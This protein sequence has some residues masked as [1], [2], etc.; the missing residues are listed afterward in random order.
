MG[1]RGGS[2]VIPSFIQ[3]ICSIHLACLDEVTLPLGGGILTPIPKSVPNC[4][5]AF[6]DE[7]FYAICLKCRCP[8]FFAGATE[9]KIVDSV[10]LCLWTVL[11]FFCV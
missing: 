2:S 7:L 3:E 9:Q 6:W 5:W 11:L 10:L 8:D 1:S 4:C